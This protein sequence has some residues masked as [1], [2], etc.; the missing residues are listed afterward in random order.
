MQVVSHE[1]GHQL[2]TFKLVVMKK[3]LFTLL[4]QT[5]SGAAMAQNAGTVNP[6]SGVLRGSGGS[7]TF[8]VGHVQS[9]KATG[10]GGTVDPFLMDGPS[11]NVIVEVKNEPIQPDVVAY[12]NPTMESIQLKFHDT[13]NQSFHYVLHSIDGKLLEQGSVYSSDTKILL[14]PYEGSTF[15]VTVFDNGVIMKRIRIIKL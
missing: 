6:A 9:M 4:F 5:L 10:G 1:R 14:T 7:V 3:L 13:T 8:S 2:N 12:P 15:V 11:A